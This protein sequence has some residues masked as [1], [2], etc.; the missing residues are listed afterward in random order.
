MTRK[1]VAKEILADIRAGMG[2]SELM[3]KYALSSLELQHAFDQIARERETRARAIATDLRQGVSDLEL[4]KTY[5]LSASAFHRILK[6]L[7]DRGFITQDDLKNKSPSGF[8]V[9]ILDLRKEARHVPAIPITICDATNQKDCA[10]NRH[11]LRDISGH[12]L[13]VKGIDVQ[14]HD[15]RRII[16]LGDDFG[17]VAPFEF[18]AECRWI[19]NE[20]CDDQPLAGFEITNIS[21]EDS[22]R[23]VDFIERF[24]ITS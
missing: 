18:E 13:A 21:Q 3:E 2:R 23:L 16:L 17:D 9:V 12:G 11:V 5:Q 20:A 10:E 19:R 8:D 22:E 24:T 15:I 14:V 1:I 4:M 7:L 6:T